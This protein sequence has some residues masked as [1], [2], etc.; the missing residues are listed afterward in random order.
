MIQRNWSFV[1]NSRNLVKRRWRNKIRVEEKKELVHRL[2]L[3]SSSNV[4]KKIDELER[5]I[6]TTYHA[7][8]ENINTIN[9]LGFL[10]LLGI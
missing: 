8:A 1:L 5:L 4:K 6:I 2:F 7:D 10:R 3:M 9:I